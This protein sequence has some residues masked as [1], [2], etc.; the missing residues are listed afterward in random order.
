M[1][2]ETR[3]HLH[4][5]ERRGA[6]LDRVQDKAHF[7]A[8]R[9]NHRGA[10]GLREQPPEGLELADLERVD[11]RERVGGRDLDQAELA[12]VGVLGDE[13]R[14]EGDVGMARQPLHELL[15][16]RIGGDVVVGAGG[17][18]RIGH[19]GDRLGGRVGRHERSPGNRKR[20]RAQL[21][22]QEGHR[23]EHRQ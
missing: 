20:S 14:V 12:A 5:E 10:A 8:A 13:F 18:S 21:E 16:L 17:S 7:L 22:K 3:R 9:V 4:V 2:D 11:H 1:I 6:G 15:E 23:G 19:A